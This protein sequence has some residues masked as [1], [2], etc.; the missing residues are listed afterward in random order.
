ML[1]ALNNS[2]LL[3]SNTTTLTEISDQLR[4][5]YPTIRL[6]GF[7]KLT[8]TEKSYCNALLQRDFTTEESV[9]SMID[10]NVGWNI[11]ISRY[12]TL[13]DNSK[14]LIKPKHYAARILEGVGSMV[15]G[16]NIFLFFPECLNVKNTHLSF[17]I[18]FV[19]LWS[20]IFSNTIFPCARTV[21]SKKT[22]AE[23]LPSLNE[24]LKESIYLASIFHE[25]GH[26]VGP[27]KVSPIKDSRNK[28]SSFYLDIL[29]ELATDSLLSYQL[30]EFRNIASFVLLQRLFWFPRRGYMDNPL[31]AQINSDNDS[32][33]GAFL[34][35]ELL[36]KKIMEKENSKWSIKWE[37]LAPFFKSIYDEI[38]LL[39]QELLKLDNSRKQDELVTEWMK[40]KVE[41][42]EDLG[43]LFHP[44][45]VKIYQ[46]CS[47]HPEI[48]QFQTLLDI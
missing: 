41:Y 40:S 13:N 46:S 35:N 48:P 32:W 9:N 1:Q 22:C 10:K 39:G 26:Q 38:D 17:G 21:L 14:P 33:I 15:S 42:H 11:L 4:N 47:R 6:E 37:M 7:F 30:K 19:D 29:G 34:W 28:L 16:K 8:K 31:A 2:R 12:E 45:Q 23:M 43:F 24:Q 3:K 18:E 27:Y 20:N 44:E 5:N 36:R 25:L